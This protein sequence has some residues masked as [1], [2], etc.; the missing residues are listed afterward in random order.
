MKGLASVEPPTDIHLSVAITCFM[1]ALLAL[2][3]TYFMYWRIGIHKKAAANRNRMAF[4]GT[5]TK[6]VVPK[7]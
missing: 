7:F 1:L 6:T 2:L 3:A 4:A 5:G